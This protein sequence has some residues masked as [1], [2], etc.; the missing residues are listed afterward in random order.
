MFLCLSISF[1]ASLSEGSAK[2]TELS[3]HARASWGLIIG[4]GL[5]LLTAASSIVVI[6]NLTMAFYKQV[7]FVPI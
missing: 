2:L 3:F 4:Y 5:L 6:I 1:L 7:D